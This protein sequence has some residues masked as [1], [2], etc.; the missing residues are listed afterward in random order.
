MEAVY[1]L[2][3]AHNRRTTSQRKDTHRGAD[4][5]TRLGEHSSIIII[6]STKTNKQKKMTVL[7]ISWHHT[8]RLPAKVL[9]FLW[10]T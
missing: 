7:T 3:V 8:Q 4:K 6:V 1:D 9:I 2:S 10:Q 5:E